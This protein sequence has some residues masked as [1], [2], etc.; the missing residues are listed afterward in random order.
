MTDTNYLKMISDFWE[1]AGKGPSEAQRDFF[2]QMAARFGATFPFA[3]FP[4]NMATSNKASEAFRDLL[5]SLMAVPNALATATAQSTPGDKKTAELLQKIMNPQEWLSATGYTDQSI[6]Q[7]VEGP[8]FADIGQLEGKFAALISAWTDLRTRALEQSTQQLM[9]W[10]KAAQEF[11]AKLGEAA[12]DK[13]LESRAQIVS[14]WVAIANRHLL[15]TQRSP[16]YLTN[17]RELLRASTAFK[18]AQTELSDYYGEAF[19]LPTR[20]EIDDLTRMVAELKREVR[21]DQR[22]RRDHGNEVADKG[23]TT[24]GAT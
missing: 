23:E 22:R 7:L 19:G 8:K 10:A 13:P 21:A 12:K 1:T 6:R 15:E 2:Q 20:G 16:E 11:T 24:H 18:R 14:L 3:A 4:T 17:Q 5:N 9:A